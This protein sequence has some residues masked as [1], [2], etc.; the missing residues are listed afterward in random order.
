[1]STRFASLAEFQDFTRASVPAGHNDGWQD[2]WPGLLQ[3]YVLPM[4]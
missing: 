1:M 2:A 3:K 4:R